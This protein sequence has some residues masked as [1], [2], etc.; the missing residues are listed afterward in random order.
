LPTQEKLRDAVTRVTVVRISGDWD[1]G[2]LAR[3]FA[4]A[5][6]E[7]VAERAQ[8]IVIEVDGDRARTDV[9]RHMLVSLRGAEVPSA[10]LLSDSREKRVGVGQLVLALAA[11]RSGIVPGVVVRGGARELRELSP[12]PAVGLERD[13][14]AGA[15]TTRAAAEKAWDE[16]ESAAA[17]LLRARLVERRL[18][19][20]L[21]ADLLM[22]IEAVWLVAARGDQ[23]ARVFV[24]RAETSEP[25]TEPP[26]DAV[27][28]WG[29]VAPALTLE[30]AGE[31]AVEVGLV[32]VATRDLRAFML[33]M[34]ARGV[35]PRRVVIASELAGARKDVVELLAAASARVL[36]AKERLRVPS[37]SRVGVSTDAYAKIAS[38]VERMLDEVMGK[39]EAIERMMERLPELLTDAPPGVTDVGATAARRVTAWR[40]RVQGVRDDVVELREKAV[41]LRAR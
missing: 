15:A 40:S 21:A 36:D 11:G 35:T 4:T 39:V 16:V 1:T 7:A 9:L 29:G 38:E 8:L 20:R 25:V 13:A 17:A 24:K 2:Q 18:P 31:K 5:I 28:I 26:A 12:E 34:D 3:D 10:V 14:G 27:Q 33:E 6:D 37:P 19:E 32:D 30:I 23:A 41:G 22:P